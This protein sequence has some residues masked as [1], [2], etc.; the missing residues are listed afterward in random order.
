MRIARLAFFAAALAFSAQLARAEY[1]V[2]KSGQR[3]VVTSY[4]LVGDTY[5]LTMPGGTAELPASEVVAI[6]PEEL[7]RPALQPR[8]VLAGIPYADFIQSAAQHHRVD[9]DLIVSVITAESKFNPKAISRKNARGLM[10]LLPQTA[11]RLGVKNI[12]DPEE[13]IEA[14]TRYLR[15]LLDRYDNNLA[16]A[17]A[18]YNAGPQR[19]ELYKSVPP[20]RETVSYVRRIQETY[21]ARKSSASAHTPAASSF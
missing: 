9:A 21:K 16:L 17:L 3:L 13:N 6:E 7:F 20:Y 2:L 8:P 10:Q 12:F 19:V 1:V 14:G 18:A 15:E 5:K 4:Q 11:A